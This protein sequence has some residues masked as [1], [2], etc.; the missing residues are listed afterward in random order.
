MSFCK[1]ETPITT[2][3][4]CT[5]EFSH[6]KK[7][8][9][10]IYVTTC[11]LSRKFRGQFQL[12]GLY[13][14]RRPRVLVLVP[15]LVRQIFLTDFHKFAY[16]HVISVKDPEIDPILSANP[17]FLNGRAWKERRAEITPAFTASRVTIAK[18]SVLEKSSIFLV[19][20]IKDLNLQFPKCNPFSCA[21]CI[22]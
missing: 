7:I 15:S 17:F 20:M 8:A 3:R 11:F 9:F 5:R 18:E 19:L 6:R 12:A 14:L 16:N 2:S 22:P 10:F 13:T 21:Q 4:T 1:N